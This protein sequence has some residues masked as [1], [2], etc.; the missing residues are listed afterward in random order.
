MSYKEK[1]IDFVNGLTQEEAE[2]LLYE[3][4]KCRKNPIIAD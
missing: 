4:T 3:L 2:K 1:L